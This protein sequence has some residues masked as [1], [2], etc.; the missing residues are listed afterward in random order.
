MGTT[1][2]PT[3]PVTIPQPAWIDSCGNL[4]LNG[5]TALTLTISFQDGSGAPLDVSASIYTFEVDAI[6]KTTLAPVSGHTD[7]QVLQLDQPDVAL[8]GVSGNPKVGPHFVLRDETVSD[9]EGVVRWEGMVIVRGF[10]QEPGVVV[11]SGL[12]PALV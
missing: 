10:T 11:V 4:R 3:G 6:L 7:Q 9:D 12:E 2:P 1:T 8:I 5:R